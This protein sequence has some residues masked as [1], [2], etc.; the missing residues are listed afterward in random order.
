MISDADE[1]ADVLSARELYEFTGGNPPSVDDLARRYAVQTCGRSADGSQEWLNFI[2][3]Q[4]VDGRAVGYVQATIPTHG[5]A[6]EIAW[7]IGQ[8]WQGRGYA[9]AAARLLLDELDARGVREVIAHIH[10]EHEASQRVALRLGLVATDTVVDGEM[11][12]VGST[13]LG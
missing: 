5:G 2:V 8:E 13:A 11:R 9:T 3:T 7:V 4:G 12:W 1:M 6:S 10:P